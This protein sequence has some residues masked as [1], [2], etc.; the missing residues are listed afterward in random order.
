MHKRT[1]GSGNLE[2]S[3]RGLGCM[4]MTHGDAPVGTRQEMIDLLHRAVDRGITFFDT[5]D[6]YGIA[7][8]SEIT[9][10]AVLGD[11]RKDIVL[12]DARD[13]AFAQGFD[14]LGIAKGWKH[15]VHR[16][17]AA[18][19]AIIQQQVVRRDRSGDG[20][21]VLLGTAHQRDT[22]GGAHCRHMHA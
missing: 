3:A 15:F 5:S 17:E 13:L 7:G 11:R 12:H 19:A 6:S 18:T 1:L 14:V 20:E 10:G 16:I 4:R 8:G 21:P 2:V 22:F 9:L